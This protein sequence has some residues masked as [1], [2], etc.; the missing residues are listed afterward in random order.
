M[1]KILPFLFAFILLAG[2]VFHIITPDFYEAI[3]P[4]FVP[5]SFANIISAIVEIAIGIALL[6]PKYRKVGA[7]AFTLLMLAFLPI[8]L[9]DLFKDIPA[10]GSKT[11]AIVRLAI[12]FILIY[13]GFWLYRKRD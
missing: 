4:D 3:T 8:H 6:L 5:L 7:L 9:W 12:Q 1:K 10:V 11:N 2:G 13:G